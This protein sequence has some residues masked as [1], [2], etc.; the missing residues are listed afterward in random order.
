METTVQKIDELEGVFSDLTPGM[1]QAAAEKQNVTL[2]Q[3]VIKRVVREL[4]EQ[5]VQS[6]TRASEIFGNGIAYFQS[7]QENLRDSDFWK[8]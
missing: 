8:D 4:N 5:G 6:G 2:P 1:V 7:V 3:E